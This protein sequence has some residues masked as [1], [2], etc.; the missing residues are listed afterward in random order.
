MRDMAIA[1]STL[2]ALYLP[3]IRAVPFVKSARL[4]VPSATGPGIA[5][6][7]LLELRTTAGTHRKLVAI[8][9]SHLGQA[10]LHRV[11]TLRDHRSWILFAP[12]V[13]RP[14]AAAL[15]EMGLDFVD[16][17]G[18]IRLA[19][20]D[21]AFA[22][23]E[24]RG[25]VRGPGEAGGW[26]APG[27]LVVFAFLARPEWLDVPVRRVAD[28]IGVSKNAVADTRLRLIRDR[29]VV[30]TSGGRKLVDPKRLRERWLA[31]FADVLWPSLVLGRFR[32]GDE[33]PRDVERRIGDLL[34]SA[35][36]RWGWGG[37]PAAER[38]VRHYRGESTTV[39]VDRLPDE[40][41]RR[42]RALPDRRGPLVFIRAP[43]PLVFE[44][45]GPTTLATPPAT[46]V[47]APGDIGDQASLLAW[48]RAAAVT[49]RQGSS[50]LGHRRFPR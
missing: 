15:G 18:N 47:A 45:P 27:L 48:P 19:L 8:I 49:W 22:L 21:K 39:W 25:R 14:S 20:G 38:L 24:G 13:S 9:G 7:A 40:S 5:P 26:R 43:G 16:R 3:T 46:A 42:L 33:A 1:T 29:F 11:R 34:P 41:L 6:D 23:V 35:G 37:G 10:L 44:G 17:A 2:E 32:T 50:G 36:V 28:S 12:Y 30:E 4:D 31:G